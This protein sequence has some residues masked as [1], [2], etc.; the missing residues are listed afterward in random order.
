M[1]SA[2]DV[3]QHN[4]PVWGQRADGLLLA[5]LTDHGLPGKWEQLW[6]RA[7]GIGDFE[8]C[9]LPFFLYGLA[10]GDVVTA[11]LDRDGNLVLTGRAKSSGRHLLRV[12][13]SSA[14]HRQVIHE[15]IHRALTGLKLMH[16]WHRDG[17][18]AIDLPADF[19]PNAAID[20]LT[21][22]IDTEHLAIEIASEMEPGIA[23]TD[24]S[25]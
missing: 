21:T 5:D 9:C 23:A 15:A 24:E 2:R 10:L 22:G 14:E 13:V 1:I 25:R 4:E 19:D 7:R 20:R 3:A 17:Y 6:V 18:A 8:I 12:A 11:A 16:E